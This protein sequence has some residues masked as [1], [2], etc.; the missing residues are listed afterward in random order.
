MIRDGFQC[1]QKGPL[2]NSEL[3][4]GLTNDY[5]LQRV[6]LDEFESQK[7][8]NSKLKKSYKEWRLKSRAY[9]RELQGS[10][11]HHG[12]RRSIKQDKF[13]VEKLARWDKVREAKDKKY[14]S[15]L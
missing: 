14:A 2:L 10:S 6:E 9:V 8:L 4:V 3:I 11:L 15:R 7:E 12:T 13:D 5:S 1:S